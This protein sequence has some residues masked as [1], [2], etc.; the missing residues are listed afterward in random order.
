MIWSPTQV[1]E[2]FLRRLFSFVAEKTCSAAGADILG[3]AAG[4]RAPDSEDAPPPEKRGRPST[5][6]VPVSEFVD[7]PDWK[8]QL[9]KRKPLSSRDD[10]LIQQAASQL[11]ETRQDEN[12][13]ML[14]GL[15][16]RF[17]PGDLAGW[18]GKWGHL[19]HYLVEA[20]CLEGIGT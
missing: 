16:A 5:P 11:S 8:R 7:I 12:L 1:A 3:P 18:R 2:P 19:Q 14:K 13:E 6:E 20:E 17:H 9:G 4:T 10:K 15:L